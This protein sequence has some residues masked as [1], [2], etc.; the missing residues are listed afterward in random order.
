MKNNTPKTIGIHAYTWFDKKYGNT[1]FSSVG[2]V[3]GIEKVKI[4]FEYG[5]GTHYQYETLKKL[6]EEGHIPPIERHQNGSTEAPHTYQRR[7]GIV[8]NCCESEV[9]RQKDLMF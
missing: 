5:Y 8:V 7:T 6:S 2:Y 9:R 3:D 1:Y 4:E